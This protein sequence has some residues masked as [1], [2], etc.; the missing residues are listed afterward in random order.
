M[1]LLMGIVIVSAQISPKFD[2]QEQYKVE[3]REKLQL[4][5]SMPDYSTNSI[6]AKVMDPRLATTLDTIYNYQQYTTLSALSVIQSC[7][8]EGLSYGRIKKIKQDTVSK[9]GNICS[10]S[11][12]YD[13][14]E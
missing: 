1:L 13:I 2:K 12:Q 11:L 14:R 7:Q 5:Y 8:V 9:Q 3:V 4:D 6:D 10:Y